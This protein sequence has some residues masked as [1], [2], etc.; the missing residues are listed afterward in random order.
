MSCHFTRPRRS[1]LFV[2]SSIFDEL[3]LSG[4]N[5]GNAQRDVIHHAE[6]FVARGR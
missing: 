1:W 3:L 6:R 5:V 2:A 4:V